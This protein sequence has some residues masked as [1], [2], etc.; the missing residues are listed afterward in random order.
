MLFQQYIMAKVL[1]NL[2]VNSFMHNLYVYYSHSLTVQHCLISLVIFSGSEV[3]SPGGLQF[4][5][6]CV[7]KRTATKIMSTQMVQNLPMVAL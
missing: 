6:T 5:I 4:S 3:P 1:C 7:W 2:M